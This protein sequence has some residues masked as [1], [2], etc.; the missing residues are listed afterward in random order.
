MLYTCQISDQLDHSNRNYSRICPPPAIPICKKP[1]LFRVK[2]TP[3]PFWLKCINLS[4][5]TKFCS[6][7][8][9]DVAD[10][11]FC[12]F[13]KKLSHGLAN[14][15]AQRRHTRQYL[16]C[17]LESLNSNLACVNR[18]THVI[19]VMVGPRR[20]LLMLIE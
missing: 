16:G 7:D 13:T 2:V 4:K 1:G 12:L 6:T 10:K 18:R 5:C 3:T 9:L 17:I 8:K 11:Y 19:F 14:T 15:G 20:S